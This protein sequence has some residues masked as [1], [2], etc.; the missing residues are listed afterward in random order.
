MRIQDQPNGFR[1]IIW[2]QE[3]GPELCSKRRVLG[4]LPLYLA[5]L[6]PEL[7]RAAIVLADPRGEDWRTGVLVCLPD[8]EQTVSQL[9]LL[10]EAL[11]I[12][13]AKGFITGAQAT[14][15]EAQLWRRR[16]LQ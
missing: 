15:A 6:D 14:E 5:F 4:A 12:A 11:S 10:L 13:Q 3:P 2:Q 1:H 8:S 7:T 16:N 9:E